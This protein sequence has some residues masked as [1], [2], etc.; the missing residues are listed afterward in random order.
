MTDL[1]VRLMKYTGEKEDFLTEC[2]AATLEKDKLFAENVLTYLCGAKVSKEDIINIKTQVSFEHSCVDIVVDLKSN[3]SIG[4]ENKLWSPEGQGYKGKGQLK[5]Y[6]SLPA[7][8]YLAFITGYYTDVD[9]VVYKNKKYLRPKNGRRHF[10]WSDFYPILSKS[11]STRTATE[12]NRALRDVFDHFGFEPAMPKI[13]NLQ[14]PDPKV[15]KRNKENFAKLWELT[16]Q[17][18]RE[19]GWKR[20]GP[21]SVAELY[22]SD[23]IAKRLNWAWIDAT[24]QPGSFRIRLNCYKKINLATIEEELKSPEFVFNKEIILRCVETNR[25]AG[26]ESAIDVMIPMRKLFTGANN[27]ETM[28][29]K[30]AEF[31]LAVFDKVG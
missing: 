15:A 8:T 4:I 17:G 3:K 14:D 10:M 23:G 31:V 2:F 30:L 19:R 13:G 26:K 11:L 5:T 21:G 20:I 25:R 18:L 24:W 29:L 16:R 6:L 1:F 12:F 22:V 7:L 28:S 27:A 9:D